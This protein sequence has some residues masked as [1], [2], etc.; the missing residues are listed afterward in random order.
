MHQSKAHVSSTKTGHSYVSV[1][2]DQHSHVLY[3][4]ILLNQ[5]DEWSADLQVREPISDSLIENTCL[6]S[7]T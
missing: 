6:Y 4:T 2:N 3:Q 7:S 5:T 1:P